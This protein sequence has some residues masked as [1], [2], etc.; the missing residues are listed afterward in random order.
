CVIAS[1]RPPDR[2]HA[3]AWA[4]VTKAVERQTR[5]TPPNRDIRVL[6]TFKWARAFMSL[7]TNV[8]ACDTVVIVGGGLSGLAAAVHLGRAGVVTIVFDEAALLGGRAK[9]ERMNGFHLNY[10]PHRLYAEGPAV[11]ALR[12]LGIEIDGAPRGPN[13]GIAVW[14]GHKYTLP[15]G[16]CSLLTTGLFDA[17]A[18]QEIARLMT[19]LRRIEL[20]PLEHVSIGEWVR[21]HLR[22]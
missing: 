3:S 4:N 20:E 11:K 22:D 17:C 7:G 13:G 21:A 19:S 16:F 18:K 6:V 12:G 10:G 2:R 15:V 1:C 8:G 5:H 9:T 14:R